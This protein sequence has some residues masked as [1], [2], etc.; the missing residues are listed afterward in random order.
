MPCVWCVWPWWS[1]LWIL[2]YVQNCSVGSKIGCLHF[3]VTHCSQH[4]C[5][6]YTD[7]TCVLS[8]GQILIISSGLQQSETICLTSACS[9]SLSSRSWS[10]G[11]VCLS[12]CFSQEECFCNDHHICHVAIVQRI[13]AF[14]AF[15]LMVWGFSVSLSSVRDSGGHP[16]LCNKHRY[17]VISNKSNHLN[18]TVH[19]H[20]CV[21][22]TTQPCILWQQSLNPR[23]Y[24]ESNK[25][26]YR[27]HTDSIH[28]TVYNS[29]EQRL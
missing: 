7:S 3:K 6:A 18:S 5:A 17:N 15:F 27:D 29:G 19:S 23:L 4:R 10:G 11:Q 2:D 22:A 26:L 8:A 13:N 24:L 14:A 1:S 16:V 28:H 21:T 20:Y 25:G 9:V 12:L